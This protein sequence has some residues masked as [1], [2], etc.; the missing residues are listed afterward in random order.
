MTT[1]LFEQ[2]SP[3]SKAKVGAK[4]DHSTVPVTGLEMVTSIEVLEK[5]LEGLK[6][7]YKGEVN[8]YMHES[9]VT[10][11]MKGHKRPINFFGEEGN[12]E[13]SLQLRKRSSVSKLEDAQKNLL[14]EYGIPF[15]T[16]TE[17]SVNSKY[18]DMSNS[19]NV[20]LLQRVST[21]LQKHCKDF[22]A[23]DFFQ[24][25]KKNIATEESID[26]VFQ[27]KDANDEYLD[28]SIVS[29][30]LQLVTTL[31]IRPKLKKSTPEKI[32]EAYDRVLQALGILTPELV[33]QRLDK[34][35]E[36]AKT[37]KPQFKK[38]K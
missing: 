20:E 15:E 33:K 16:I 5:A 22:P 3:K 34:L 24:V 9:F 18:T 13:A 11:G 4:S 2:A 12:S 19:D 21:A 27:K 7:V 25:E 30:L 36:Y 17:F 29:N 26:V 32:T 14:T 23:A 31:G 37:T 28:R 6:T 8:T 10:D 35:P 1:N 38:G